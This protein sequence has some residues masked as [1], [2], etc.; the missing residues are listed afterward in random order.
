MAIIGGIPHFQTYPYLIIVFT[1]QTFWFWLVQTSNYHSG[2]Y[3]CP[4]C[5]IDHPFF[6]ILI[7]QHL[8]QILSP[9]LS[10]ILSPIFKIPQNPTV[11]Y[12]KTVVFLSQ[13][14][15]EVV[16]AIMGGAFII[17]H[18]GYNAQLGLRLM[19]PPP[20]SARLGLVGYVC[21]YI[22]IYIYIY[23]YIY[24]YRY[25]VY[26]YISVDIIPHM[27]LRDSGIWMDME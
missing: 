7:I 13:T 25:T 14:S 8:S 3:L 21:I 1:I 16:V 2:G 11:F 19:D 6:W 26:I 23:T 4:L 27:I 9:I 15:A 17:G 5:P 20:G 22:Y 12:A 24:I 10:L 18:R